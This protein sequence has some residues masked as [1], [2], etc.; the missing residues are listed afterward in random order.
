MENLVLARAAVST[1]ARID[2]AVT[3][4]RRGAWEYFVVLFCCHLRSGRAILLPRAVVGFLHDLQ[5][6]SLGRAPIGQ[7]RSAQYRTS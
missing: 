7:A 5:P 4:K 3:L 2:Y 1:L 6:G